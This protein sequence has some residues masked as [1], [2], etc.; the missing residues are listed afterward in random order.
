MNE[1]R[2]F[3]VSTKCGH[4]GRNKYILIDF[5]VTAK[6]A[7]DAAKVARNIPRVKHHWKNAIENVKEVSYEKYY[8]QL[9][10][11]SKDNYLKAKC[12]QDQHIMCINL[13]ERV[14]NCSDDVNPNELTKN[15]HERIRYQMKKLEILKKHS[16]I[17]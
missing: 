4:V 8:K 7:K 10:I 13:E 3:I 14:I 11:N 5:A 15:R 1:N 12:I 9:I 2:K 16:W 6:S 17:I